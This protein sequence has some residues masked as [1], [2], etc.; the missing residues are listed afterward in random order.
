M[1]MRFSMFVTQCFRNVCLTNE[2]VKSCCSN[3]GVKQSGHSDKHDL[4]LRL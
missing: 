3:G 2:T 4:T 1:E